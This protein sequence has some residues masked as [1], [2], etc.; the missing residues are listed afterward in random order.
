MKS[1]LSLYNFIPIIII[2]Q[3]I[4]IIKNVFHLLILFFLSNLKRNNKIKKKKKGCEW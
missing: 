1:L 3:L 2:K 4:Q